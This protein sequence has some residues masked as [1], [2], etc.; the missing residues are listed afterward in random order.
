MLNVSL[1]MRSPHLITALTVAIAISVGVGVGVGGV[2]AAE[3]EERRAELLIQSENLLGALRPALH[4]IEIAASNLQIPGKNIPRGLFADDVEVIDIAAAP[5]PSGEKFSIPGIT[6]E[7]WQPPATRSLRKAAGLELWAAFFAGV[8]DMEYSHFYF[9][10]ASFPNPEK[11]DVL[12]TLIGFDGVA[13]LKDGRWRSI[14]ATQK[15]RWQKA[16]EIWRITAWHQQRF[17]TKTALR[18]LFREVLDEAIPDADTLARAR[19]SL[20]EE[21]IVKLFTTG[22]VTLPKPL[23][24]KYPNIDSLFQHPAVAVTDIDNDGLDDIYVMGRWGRN[25]LLRNRGDGTFEDIAAAIG[26]DIDGLC[27]CA[28]FADFDNDGDKDVF[29]GRSLERTLY[30][31]NVAGKFFESSKQRVAARLPYLVSTISAADFNNDGLLDVFLGLYGPTSPRNPIEVWAKDFFPEPFAKVIIE[32]AKNSHRYL[33][34]TGPPNLLLVNRGGRFEVPP[35]TEQLAEWL[36]TF[37]G[38]WAD[39]DND[40]DQDIYICNDFGGDHLF[41]NELVPSGKAAFTNVSGDVTG[42]LMGFGMGASWGDYDRDGDLDLYVS[43][44]FSKA[45]RRITSR[46]E[47]LDKRIYLAAEGNHLF[48]NQGGKF[49]QLAGLEEPA[50]K[51][52]RVG[53][54]FGGQ[55]FDADADGWPDISC[56]SGFYTAPEEI[57]THNDL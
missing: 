31:E 44:M 52:A 16:G 17:E 14:A 57:A 4:H 15:V 28:L 26:L 1:P 10:D 51:V 19:Q 55:F 8:A 11:L 20:H 22:Q 23:H 30:F 13:K 40:G 46:F 50:L 36:H 39:Y 42:G 54:A 6:G 5:T 53:W 12:E 29:L 18:R 43:N 2:C 24:V 27:N 45:G 21:N 38:A 9:T 47:N 48:R 49:E 37:Q 32:R 34:H 56:P 33:D 25:Q 35:Q 3:T 41:R 7:N